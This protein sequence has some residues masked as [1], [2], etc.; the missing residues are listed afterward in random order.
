VEGFPDFE[1]LQHCTSDC[2]HHVAVDP[3]IRLLPDL[4]R[5]AA[6]ARAPDEAHPVVRAGLQRCAGRP[7]FC[8]W[9]LRIYARGLGW[10]WEWWLVCWCGHML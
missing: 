5:L 6:A 4:Q 9:P 3:G 10:G 1:I 2:T 7:V 8:R